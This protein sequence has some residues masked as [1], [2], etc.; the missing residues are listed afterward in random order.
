SDTPTRAGRRGLLLLALAVTAVISPGALVGA[1][2]AK[3]RPAS[4]IVVYRGSVANVGRK[5]TALQRANG[6]R[7]D[8]R[9]AH[10]LKGFA[11]YL[12]SQQVERLRGNPDVAFVTPDRTVEAV[13]TAPLHS[14]DS[15]P[16]GVLR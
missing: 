13:G 6:F 11:A 14:G 7:S 9:Y 5:T 4:Y 2:G 10:A 15:I 12:S 16:T 3:H 1:A 8:F